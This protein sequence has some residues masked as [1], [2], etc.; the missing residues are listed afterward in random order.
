MSDHR[1]SIKE[2]GRELIAA[3]EFKNMTLEQIV[4]ITKIGIDYLKAMEEGQWDFLPRPYMEVFLR[5]YAEAVGMNVPKVMKK[6]REM[7]LIEYQEEE[8]EEVENT[9][10]PE[11]T[12]TEYE[13]DVS[14]LPVRKIGLVAGGIGL[15][16]LIVVLAVIL[17]PGK[18]PPDS[19]P[20][21][22]GTEATQRPAEPGES[23]EEV[24]GEG[25]SQQ[26]DAEPSVPSDDLTATRRP[27]S[28]QFSLRARAREQCWL[29]A[30][31]D[32]TDVRDM[33]LRIDDQV[34]LRADK[35]IHL[36]IGNAGGLELSLEGEV[37]DSLGP[38]GRP[39]TI[40]IGPDGIISQRLG[41]WQ[42]NYENEI[43]TPDTTN[44]E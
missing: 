37:L 42:V 33:L 28:D 18:E 17:F 39:V 29:K 44:E 1:E 41:A 43:E 22:E 20:S 19:P 38:P 14:L 40:V 16:I 25:T 10:E 34:T 11:E 2:F 3:R 7:V 32:Q 26:V 6:Y 8:Q 23:I 31:M 27:V 13:T 5:S 12:D 30:T 36:V 4:D 21:R 9:V 24:T 15:L 35:E